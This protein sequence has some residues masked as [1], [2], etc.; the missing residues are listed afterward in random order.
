VRSWRPLEAPGLRAFAY[1]EERGELLELAR[2]WLARG[3]QPE[4]QVL[5]EGR[6]WR[7]GPYA[8]KR[9]EPGLSVRLHLRPSHARRNAQ[10]HFALAPVPTPRP[11]LVLEDRSGA[12]LL[13]AEFVAGEF[14][15]HLWNAGGP[16][17][18][19]FAGFMAEMHR[20]GVFHGDFH[21]GNALWTGR[22]WVLLDLE[23]VRARRR[24]LDRRT[25]VLDQWARVHLGL[26][27]ARGLQATFRTY[28]ELRGLRWDVA[29]VWPEIVARSRS[30]ALARGADP[31]YVERDGQD[32]TPWSSS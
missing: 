10:L 14:L 26:R 31:A 29:R 16:G 12:S 5:K 7:H 22:A 15:H 3:P 6:V 13:V 27:G 23:G 8:V 4:D 30:L 18:E 1:G 11:Y 19:A 24:T 25:L 9:F 28:L 21:L 20:H 32:P 2:A 17:V